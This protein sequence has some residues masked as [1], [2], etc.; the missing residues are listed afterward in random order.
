M[1]ELGYQSKKFEIYPQDNGGILGLGTVY[2]YDENFFLQEWSDIQAGKKIR[3]EKV[4]KLQG[5]F[6]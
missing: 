6:G 2:K 4:N 1:W 5:G 3:A